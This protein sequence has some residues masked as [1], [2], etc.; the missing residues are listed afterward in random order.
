MYSAMPGKADTRAILREEGRVVY[1]CVCD[2]ARRKTQR[3]ESSAPR[4]LQEC[5]KG[6]TR[7]S[8]VRPV[9]KGAA[10]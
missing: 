5:H 7:V 1:T 2:S 8:A 3:A 10:V 9:W 4:V 6:V